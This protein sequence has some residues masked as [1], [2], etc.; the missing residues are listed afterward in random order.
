M[1]THDFVDVRVIVNGQ[2]LQEYLEPEDEEAGENQLVRYI[3]AA[4]DQHFE[5]S[6]RWLPGFQLKNALNLVH[7]LTMD[8]QFWVPHQPVECKGLLSSNTALNTEASYSY[9][10]ASLDLGQGQIKKVSFTFGA[11][12]IGMLSYPLLC[13]YQKH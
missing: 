7:F 8:G 12:D 13:I 11:L 10:S 5:V 6:I 4:V 2:P 3:E 1:P 9:K